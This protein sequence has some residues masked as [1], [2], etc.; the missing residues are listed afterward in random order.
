MSV[1]L[2]SRCQSVSGSASVGSVLVWSVSVRQCQ[3]E[4]CNRCQC[5]GVI[6]PSV[7]VSSVFSIPALVHAYVRDARLIFCMVNV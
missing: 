5:V 6:G 7:S 3:C 1:Y 2:C 4:R